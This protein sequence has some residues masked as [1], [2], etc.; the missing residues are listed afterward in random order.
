MGGS[1]VEWL[2]CWTQGALGPGFKSLLQRCQLTVFGKL[3]TPMMP[4]FTKQ[5]N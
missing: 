3:F 2:A 1:A 5:Q 4:L